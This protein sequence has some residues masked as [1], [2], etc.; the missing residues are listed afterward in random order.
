M[1]IDFHFRKTGPVPVQ[2]FLEVDKTS[3][4][5]RTPQLL[6]KNAGTRER[7]VLQM[8]DIW[9]ILRPQLRLSAENMGLLLLRQNRR[10]RRETIS[11]FRGNIPADSKRF[12]RRIG[13]EIVEI[14]DAEVRLVGVEHL[15]GEGFGVVQRHD[16]GPERDALISLVANQMKQSLYNWNKDGM[17]EEKVAS[18]LAAYTDG[19]VQIDLEHFHFA[20]VQS[21]SLGGTGLRMQRKNNRKRN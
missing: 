2:T 7:H 10:K 5:L 11:F 9:N 1:R 4:A 18:D 17:D 13:L 8:T 21:R 20:S 14:E 3:A 6:R 12:M 16:D 19:K 15:E